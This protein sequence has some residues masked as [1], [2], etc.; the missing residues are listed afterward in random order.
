MKKSWTYENCLTEA[1]KHTFISSL[2]KA[3]KS[4]YN[5]I[6]RKKWKK[7][8]FQHMKQRRDYSKAHI[9]YD[10]KLCHEE[11]L[12]Y[13][14]R[15]EFHEKAHRAYKYALKNKIMDKV[16]FHMESFK[17]LQRQSRMI[18]TYEACKKEAKKY[19]TRKKFSK[20]SSGAYNR[21][22][23]EGFL[24]EICKHM[25]SKSE[26]KKIYDKKLYSDCKN[27]IKKYK[28]KTFFIKE[29]QKMYGRILHRGWT[30]ELLGHMKNKPK[31][32]KEKIL[33]GRFVKWTYEKCQNKVK[34]YS[35]RL[36]FKKKN[37]LM[38]SA[39]LKK[40]WEKTL[41]GHLPIQKKDPYWTFVRCQEVALKCSTKTQFRK[42]YPGAYSAVLKSKWM[43]KV[44][45]HMIKPLG[46][47]WTFA[48]CKKLALECK[49]K[50]EFSKKYCSAYYR[51][52][53]KGWM[54]KISKHMK[55][56]NQKWPLEAL[57]KEA[58]KYK[59][60]FDFKIKSSG[61]YSVAQNKGYLPK[62]C[63]HMP[64]M[65]KV[66]LKKCEV[67]AVHKP[68][69]KLITGL[70]FTY[71]QEYRLARSSIID[72]KISHEKIDYSIGIEL[73]RSDVLCLER[74]QMERYKRLV[75][76]KQ[77]NI[78]ALFFVDP[79]GRHHKRGFISFKELENKLKR[80]LEKENF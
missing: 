66:N 78:K 5:K 12:K 72:L 6:L 79:K 17:Q 58:L 60:R 67:N 77:H 3:N 38:Y 4:C 50:D 37:P 52:L 21:A 47:K 7:E 33:K 14:T 45:S 23:A 65:A 53:K 49:S 18:W 40:G 75:N 74:N 73:K 68:A 32:K 16:C 20:N 29:N 44:S 51:S 24:D 11:A 39:I 10:F 42:K 57:K 30:K 59:T 8:M 55:P 69:I 76:L 1:K 46:Q 13:K 28:Y 48:V 34:N 35:S 64:K 19:Q 36:E 71:I 2:K 15:N 22:I 62:I 70:G 54:K 56:E 26:L 27:T 80:L 43:D 63:K 9:Q 31:K 61:A 41:L 25:I